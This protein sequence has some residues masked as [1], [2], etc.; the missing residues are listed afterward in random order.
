MYY[1]R[2]RHLQATTEIDMVLEYIQPILT[3]VT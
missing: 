2:K 1:D 3:D